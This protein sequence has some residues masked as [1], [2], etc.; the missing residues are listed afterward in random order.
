MRSARALRCINFI[1]FNITLRVYCFWLLVF[2]TTGFLVF[3]LVMGALDCVFKWRL[4]LAI[5]DWLLIILE[6]GGVAYLTSTVNMD[7]S[8][9]IIGVEV[10]LAL[11]LAALIA[12]WIFRTATI[13]RSKVPAVQQPFD[14]LGECREIRPPYTP[15]GILLNRSVARPLVSNFNNQAPVRIVFDPFDPIPSIR[16]SG[17]SHEG[18]AQECNMWPLHAPLFAMPSPWSFYTN[19]T[20]CMEFSQQQRIG[21]AYPGI[22]DELDIRKESKG[23]YVPVG[24]HLVTFLEWKVKKKI[25]QPQPVVSF[26]PVMRTIII[27]ELTALQPDPS[28]P[29]TC[30][31]PH[32]STLTLISWNVALGIHIK[33]Y[34]D[35]SWLDAVAA[36]GGFWTFVNGTFAVIFG[37][38]TVYFLFRRRPLSVLGVIHIF[39]RRTLARNWSADFPAIHSEGGQPGTENAG[40]V[41]FIRERLV[42]LDEDEMRDIEDAE[43]QRCSQKGSH[44]TNS[45]RNSVYSRVSVGAKE[46][47]NE[48]GNATGK[49]L[50]TVPSISETGENGRKREGWI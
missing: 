43:D 29:S 28:P 44:S 7:G 8:P 42:D 2:V 12:S 31:G 3:L 50:N 35:T 33:E 49:V 32:T 9:I 19:I 36:V 20:I 6:I 26:N 41:A 4:K 40:I 14:L 27:S 16:V 10:A 37:A 24:A 11:I 23:I 18:T 47:E 39:Q 1:L 46:V 45:S 38:N 13:Y 30:G 21:V 34:T 17:N 15:A 22:G 48:D 25:V 5:V